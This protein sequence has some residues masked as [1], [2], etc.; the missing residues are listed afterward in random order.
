MTSPILDALPVIHGTLIGI[1]A[2]FFSVFAMSGFQK[3]QETKEKLEKAQN[4]TEAM[5][6]PTMFS[7]GGT[8]DDLLLEGGDELDWRKIQLFLA[9]TKNIFLHGEFDDKYGVSGDP[10]QPSPDELVATFRKLCLVLHL[11]FVSYP[12][13]GNSINRF[14]ALSD[15]L[16]ERKN[17]SSVDMKRITEMDERAGFLVWCWSTSQRSLLELGR[18]VTEI[19]RARNIQAQTR[20]FEQGLA[21]TPN[22]S[23]DDKNRIWA[24]FYAPRLADQIDYRQFL[25]E[26]FNKAHALAANVLPAMREAFRTDELWNNRYHVRRTTLWA[27]GLIVAILIFG[28]L[29]PLVMANGQ[30]DYGW[31]WGPWLEYLLLVFTAAPYFWIC[32]YLYRKV[33]GLSFK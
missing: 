18:A 15:K 23:D 4:E 6:S 7:G 9:Q 33:Y 11:L 32:L 10:S 16:D 17:R 20:L 1:G 14:G 2:A 30:R 8:I 27:I 22:A 29:T 31:T 5:S 21:R 19:H 24:T 13:T 26:H 12:F 25:L 3:V 28:V